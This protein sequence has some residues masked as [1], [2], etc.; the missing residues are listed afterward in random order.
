[1]ASLGLASAASGASTVGCGRFLTVH[2]I[3]CTQASNISVAWMNSYDYGAAR[4]RYGSRTWA[5]GYAGK[6]RQGYQPWRC[7]SHRVWFH[8]EWPANY[9]QRNDTCPSPDLVDYFDGVYYGGGGVEDTSLSIVDFEH[10]AGVS[11]DYA[12]RFF[13]GMY[14]QNLMPAS[15]GSGTFGYAGQRWHCTTDGSPGVAQDHWW[16]DIY[17]DCTSLPTAVTNL[18]QWLTIDLGMVPVVACTG[19]QTYG[20]EGP[21]SC[22]GQITT[23]GNAL[24]D[25]DLPN[26][27][28]PTAAGLHWENYNNCTPA[29]GEC[30]SGNML[31]PTPGAI[32]HYALC[33]WRDVGPQQIDGISEEGYVCTYG[34]H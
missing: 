8:L 12:S 2:E 32:N 30:G 10:T 33:I 15:N 31:V 22:A 6:P 24:D 5:C 28:G 14:E 19:N 27:T 9:N 25:G 13:T 7:V 17:I 16:S 4:F 20:P 1:M 34:G 26:P 11:C 29:G 23:A 3:S 18:R 21:Q